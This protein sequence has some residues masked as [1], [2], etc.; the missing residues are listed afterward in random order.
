MPTRIDENYDYTLGQ[1]MCE[2]GKIREG[3]WQELRSAI[4]VLLKMLSRDRDEI[5]RLRQV[6]DARQT[7]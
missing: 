1:F 2:L 7:D 3:D 5:A 4:I 6:S